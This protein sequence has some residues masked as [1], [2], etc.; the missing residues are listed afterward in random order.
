MTE[1][2]KHEAALRAAAAQ[3][4]IDD[5]GSVE[6]ESFLHPRSPHPL[7]E[8]TASLPSVDLAASARQEWKQHGAG[9]TQTLEEKRRSD[10]PNSITVRVLSAQTR[11]DASGADYTAYVIRVL[12]HAHSEILRERRYSDFAKLHAL[13]QRLGVTLDC[14]FPA[15]SW[16]GRL[17]TWHPARAWAPE[18][19]HDLVSFRIVQLDVWLVHLMEQYN[20]A[21]L[22]NALAGAVYEFLMAEEKPPCEQNNDTQGDKWKWNNPLSF[23]LGS[24]IRQATYTIQYMCDSVLSQS[25]QSIPLDLLH[26]SKGLL[27]MTVAKGGLVISGRAG[28]G[29]VVARLSDSTWSAP[30]AVGTV[31]MGWGA[32]IGG[33]VTHYLVVLTTEKA[34]QDLVARSSV[35]LGAELGVAVGP[36][37]RGATGQVQT[38]DWALHPAYAYAH[39][40][41]LFAGISVEGS[42]VS[43][44]NDV[45][46]RFYGRTCAARDILVRQG[47]KAAE[48]LYRALQQAMQRPLPQDSFRPSQLW[49]QQ[50]SASSCISPPLQS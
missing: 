24:A 8:A 44:R 49:S 10:H 16:A 14:S 19:Y 20:R 50:Q 29:L 5:E 39:S 43:V 26:H 21:Q 11:V 37:G 23:T 35:Q 22:P 25:D 45:N 30:V 38:G 40:Q 7:E 9:V 12:P 3:E 34:V 18:Q 31:G 2:L 42:V 1:R 32:L 13:A 27:L 41:G 46:A 6:Y 4:N 17:G 15:K 36:V 47:V 28:T 33:D 48:P